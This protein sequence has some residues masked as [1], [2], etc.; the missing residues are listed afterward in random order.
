MPARRSARPSVLAALLGAALAVL[1]WA[2]WSALEP[3]ESPTSS[4][5]MATATAATVPVSPV[6]TARVD[7]PAAVVSPGLVA[8]RPVAPLAPQSRALP[9]VPD[10]FALEHG[11]LTSVRAPAGTT[12][13][14]IVPPAVTLPAGVRPEDAVVS[15]TGIVSVTRA[16]TVSAGA[17]PTPPRPVAA[18]HSP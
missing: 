6:P 4:G 12:A 5:A 7:A 1:A 13:V 10:G 15:P 17:A 9:V 14:A 11:Q 18:T 2:G 3:R 8:V 16:A